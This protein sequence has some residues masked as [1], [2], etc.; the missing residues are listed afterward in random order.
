MVAAAQG[1]ERVGGGDRAQ[2]AH[3]L[4]VDRVGRFGEPPAGGLAVGAHP[5]HAL[6]LDQRQRRAAHALQ[7]QHRR[8]GRVQGRRDGGA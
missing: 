1:D 8:A 2:A 6:R 7:A 4:H 3:E 5:Q